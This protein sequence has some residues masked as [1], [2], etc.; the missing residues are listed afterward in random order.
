M[1]IRLDLLVIRVIV[2]NYNIKIHSVIRV[3]S[4][5]HEWV[6]SVRLADSVAS[7]SGSLRFNCA[8]SALL[9]SASE[10]RDIYIRHKRPRNHET[11]RTRVQCLTLIF[12]NESKL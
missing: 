3:I 11:T 8:K 2:V 5:I 7:W 1:Q 10:R 12:F 6:V 9:C 4:H